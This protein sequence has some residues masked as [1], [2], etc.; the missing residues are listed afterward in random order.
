VKMGST[1]DLWHIHCPIEGDLEPVP[2]SHLGIESSVPRKCAL[3]PYLFEG[4][5]LWQADKKPFSLEITQAIR[6][7]KDA[8]NKAFQEV[9]SNFSPS[10]YSVRILLVIEGDLP[11][12]TPAKIREI[13]DAFHRRHQERE[14]GFSVFLN[15]SLEGEA[16][17]YVVQELRC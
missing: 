1:L 9:I 15:P 17:I 11:D 16:R 4:E 5:C 3:C 14:F 7:E 10:P 2:F 6:S 13:V 12:T 8:L